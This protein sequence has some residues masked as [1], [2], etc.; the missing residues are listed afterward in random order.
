[1]DDRFDRAHS[2]D[3]VGRLKEAY[4]GTEARE[5]V[6]GQ[7]PSGVQ[8][9]P[10]RQSYTYDAFGNLTGRENRFSRRASLISVAASRKWSC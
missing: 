9:G 8:D 7:T 2:Y 10:Y 1:M 4:T 3:H 5:F 6:N